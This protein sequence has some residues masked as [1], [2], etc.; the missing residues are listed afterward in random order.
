MTAVPATMRVSRYPTSGPEQG[1]LRVDEVPVPAP[2]PGEVLV[3]LHVAGVNPTDWKARAGGGM[4]SV[5]DEWVIPGQD[6]A[7]VVVA[8][9]E[10]VDPRREGQRVWV[11]NAQ[12][13]RPHGAAAEYIAL[14]DEL[15][16]PLPDGASFDLGAGLGI[17]AI[18]AHACL[19]TDG[20]LDGRRVLVAG[21]A[22]AVGH[23]AV[24]LAKWAGAQVAA[25]V[26]SPEKAA[27]V[28]DADL[29][30]DYKRQDVAEEVRRWAPDGVDR[31]VEVDLPRN[32]AIDEAVLA[33]YGV[34]ASY[35]VPEQPVE[36][37]RTLMRLNA[38]IRFV[39]VYTISA[40]AR[41]T[42]VRDVN[43]AVEAGVLTAL[44]DHRFDLDHVKDAHDAVEAGAVGKVLIDLV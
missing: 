43:A 3:R 24:Q 10:G 41:A 30:I 32:L 34:V 44:P 36:L 15:V 25:T 22:G 42:A 17:P 4:A 9:G 21:G 31:V 11:H 28:P 12:W 33:P 38:A 27:L 16:A 7:G 1:K 8:T 35:A 23:A 14:A 40:E 26:S 39:L 13:Q 5:G 6:G 37:S 29:V 19:F 20:P 18:T 2:G